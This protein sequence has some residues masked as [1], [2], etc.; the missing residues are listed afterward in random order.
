MPLSSSNAVRQLSDGNSQGTVLGQSATDLIGFYGVSTPVARAVMATTAATVTL[1]DPGV[2]SSNGVGFSTVA[3]FGAHVSTIRLV[4]A[5]LASLR[6]Q[7]ANLG[8][9]S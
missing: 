2:G 4:Q 6:T 7:L 9:V 8:I 1:T 3:Q 5:D